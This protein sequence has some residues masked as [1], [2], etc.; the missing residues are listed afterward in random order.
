MTEDE[1]RA[2]IKQLAEPIEPP[3]SDIKG[4]KVIVLDRRNPAHRR[5]VAKT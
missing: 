2:W 3:Q 4:G 1:R 5:L